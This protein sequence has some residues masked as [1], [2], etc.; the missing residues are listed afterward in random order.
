M[1]FSFL[2][3]R[4]TRYISPPLRPARYLT[5]TEER[6]ACEATLRRLCCC[7]RRRKIQIRGGLRCGTRAAIGRAESRNWKAIRM[8]EGLLMWAWAD[9]RVYMYA[10]VCCLEN[11]CSPLGNAR[12]RACVK[13]RKRRSFMLG[14]V[15]N[16]LAV[17]SQG[18]MRIYIYVLRV[19]RGVAA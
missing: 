17:G 4:D 3:L 12:A 11:R 8:A 10:R 13:E 7:A 15:F 16:K 1:L 2:N 5:T 14:H 18:S 6:C 19:L 9:S